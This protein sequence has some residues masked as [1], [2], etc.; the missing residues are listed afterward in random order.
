MLYSQPIK[1][2]S[3]Y[4]FWRPRVLTFYTIISIIMV[5]FFILFWAPMQLS[6]VS[7]SSRYKVAEL[8]SYIFIYL[9]WLVCG[10]KFTVIDRE[11][12]PVDGNPYIALSNHQSFWENFFMQII[13]PEHSWVIKKELFDIFTSMHNV[14]NSTDIEDKRFDNMSDEK[15][16]STIEKLLKLQKT[17]LLLKKTKKMKK[18]LK[19]QINLKLL[20]KLIFKKNNCKQTIRD[21]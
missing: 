17:S 2:S 11:K 9:L 4:M 5:L 21:F 6:N 19:F 14:K 16:N 20:M 1:L 15:F 18:S 10:I 12:L 3:I 8:F 7:Y 13:I